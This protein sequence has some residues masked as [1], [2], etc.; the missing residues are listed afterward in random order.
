MKFRILIASVAMVLLMFASAF[1]FQSSYMPT[2]SVL[3]SASA[4]SNTPALHGNI[5]LTPAVVNV[6]GNKAQFSQY[7]DLTGNG[8][9][10]SD[11]HIGYDSNDYWLKLDTTDIGYKDQRDELSG[12]MYDKFKYSLYYNQI[13]HNITFDAISPLAG[14]G[15]TNL[16]SGTGTWSNTTL[17][18]DTSKWHSFDYST[19]RDQIGGKFDVNLLD[20]LTA[21]FSV[22]NEH[23][24]GIYPLG[25]GSGGNGAI[26]L[27]VPIDW[28]TQDYNASL[29]YQARP[30]FAQAGFLYSNFNDH[31]QYVNFEFPS[32]NFESDTLSMPT[33]NDYYKFF[34]KGSLQLPYYSHVNVN[35]GKSRYESSQDLTPFLNGGNGNI[36]HGNTLD[37]SNEHYIGMPNTTTFNGK[38]DVTNV[39][40]TLTSNPIQWLDGRLFYK[41]YDSTNNS[42]DVITPVGNNAAGIATVS[43]LVFDYKTSTYGVDLGWALPMEFHLDTEYSLVHTERPNPAFALPSTNDNIYY[44]EFRWDGLDWLT[45]RVSFRDFNRNGR[46]IY[47]PSSPVPVQ[48]DPEFGYPA[49]NLPQLLEWFNIAAQHSK[50]Y[51]AEVDMSPTDNFD[52]DVAYQYNTT[53]YPDNLVGLLSSRTNEWDVDSSYRVGQVV[54]FD[55]YFDL[56]NVKTDQIAD[57]EAAAPSSL[58]LN[59]TTQYSMD[60]SVKN[61]EYEWGL[62]STVYVI[63]GKLTFNIRYDYMNSDGRNDYT[64]LTDEPLGSLVTKGVTSGFPA[65]GANE[66]NIDPQYDTY[67][68][69]AVSAKLMYNFTKQLSLTGGAEFDHYE[70]NDTALNNYQNVYNTG[71]Y[72]SASVTGPFFLTGAYSA[73]SYNANTEFVTLAYKF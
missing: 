65:T 55:G 45:P 6:S 25:G 53:F 16:V 63:P 34:L 26:E 17:P 24:T 54:R 58:P 8:G 66:S 35:V 11:I 19:R 46:G 36:F 62:G 5:S 49:D 2:G 29:L 12:G 38:R 1:A 37:P 9:L 22:L 48:T 3:P 71:H 67:K 52:F 31:D 41:Y 50:T 42:S 60:Q 28:V 59:S 70:Y 7:R 10:F 69:S 47:D 27:P 43:P 64:I 57:N 44:A 56:D 33:G 20:S 21:D 40:V 14:V 39:D 61:Y 23:K 18:T 13:L 32:G 4:V 15:S 51:K 73:P 68:D 30:L 72:Q